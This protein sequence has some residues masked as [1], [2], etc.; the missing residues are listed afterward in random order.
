MK[1][2][3]PHAVPLSRQAVAILR[4][5]EAVSGGMKYVF[6]TSRTGRCISDMAMNTAL[7]SMAEPTTAQRT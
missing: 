6:P 5:L 7:R 2:K 1:M 3:R 4:E